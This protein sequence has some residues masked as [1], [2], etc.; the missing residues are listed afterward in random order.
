MRFAALI[1]LI[2]AFLGQT[3]AAQAID[4]K[5]G[6]AWGFKDAPSPDATVI[7]GL[8]EKETSPMIVHVAVEG[9]PQL[10]RDP[11]VL[12]GGLEGRGA[13][14][15][16][17]RFWCVYKLTPSS[18]YTSVDIV[19]QYMPIEYDALVSS[20]IELKATGVPLNNRFARAYD[21]WDYFRDEYETEGTH[22]A[23][24]KKP[25]SESVETVIKSANSLMATMKRLW[26]E[27]DAAREKMEKGAQ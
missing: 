14:R 17:E 25:L 18:D 8:V 1:F 20:L 5:P 12:R 24:A 3:A 9:L 10:D 15:N 2:G 23:I 26:P 7:I 21:D 11:E 13:G 22:A 16:E 6:Q 4:I 19:I 27:L